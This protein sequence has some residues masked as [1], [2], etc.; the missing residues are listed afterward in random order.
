MPLPSLILV[1]GLACTADLWRDQV[2]ALADVA[3]IHV[4]SEHLRHGTIGSMATAILASAPDRFTLAGLS[5]GGYIVLEIMRQAAERVTGLILLDTSARADTPEQTARRQVLIELATASGMTAVISELLPFMLHPDRR[6]D[7]DLIRRVIA[8][9]EACGVEDF[10]RQQ[11]AII[12]RPD[13]RSGLGEI[14]CPTVVACGDAD[15]IT[16]PEW[17]KEMAALIPDAQLTMI[18]AC[19]HMSSMERPSL[20]TDILRAFLF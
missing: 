5:M 14:M 3:D 2:A 10:I 15:L 6:N 1:P 8:M 19:G 7:N 12:G 20:V 13:S 16:L 11:Q 4:T 18:T 17:S 9:G